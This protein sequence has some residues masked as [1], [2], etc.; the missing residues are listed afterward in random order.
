MVS[1]PL[2]CTS[3]GITGSDTRF[4]CLCRLRVL[5]HTG[6]SKKL[7]VSG[8]MLNLEPHPIGIWNWRHLE[9]YI[10]QNHYIDNLKVAP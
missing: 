5:E 10:F 3:R 1:G 7:C 9:P 8:I 6:L 2:K 4:I